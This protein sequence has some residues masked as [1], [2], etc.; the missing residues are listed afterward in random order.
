MS[1]VCYGMRSRYSLRVPKCLEVFRTKQNMCVCYFARTVCE[2]LN[3]EFLPALTQCP[4][5][6]ILY[7]Y[8]SQIVP[9]FE[10]RKPVLRVEKTVA[11]SEKQNSTA[12][13]ENLNVKTTEDM[14]KTSVNRE[15]H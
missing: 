3:T 14:E 6:K 8:I 9:Q 1:V 12:S 15:P 4:H 10:K 2:R 5:D 11:M 13:T 7:P